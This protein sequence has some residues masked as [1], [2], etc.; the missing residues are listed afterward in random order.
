MNHFYMNERARFLP[1]FGFLVLV[2]LLNDNA[3]MAQSCPSSGTTS[4]TTYPN[5]YYPASTASAAAGSKTITL[6]ASSFGTTPIA[7]GDILLVIQMQGTWIDSLNSNVYGSGAGTGNG[8]INNANLLAGNME[9][10]VAAS[11]VPIG[12]GALTLLNPLV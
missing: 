2:C 6:G 1:I 10:V 8:Y 11:N 7:S 4:I 5:T 9:F 3:S 12:G